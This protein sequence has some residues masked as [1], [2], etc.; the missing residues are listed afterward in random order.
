[1]LL[2]QQFQL[3]SPLFYEHFC[4]LSLATEHFCL[5]NV[6]LVKQD[7]HFSGRVKLM[8][9]ELGDSRMLIVL[10]YGE[11]HCTNG[12]PTVELIRSTAFQSIHSGK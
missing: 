2:S 3:L 6:L 5:L 1:M 7:D 10:L 12:W 9:Y 4:L 8:L 11:H